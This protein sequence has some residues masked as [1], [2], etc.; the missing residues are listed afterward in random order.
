MH[1]QN[2]TH[3]EAYLEAVESEELPIQRAFAPTDDERLTREMILQMKLGR[4]DASYFQDKFGIDVMSR[5]SAPFA[6]LQRRSMLDL[7]DGGATL[8]RQ[9]LLRVDTLLPE[10]YDERYQNARYT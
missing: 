10:F 4:V 7:H 6:R 3:W 9:G 1:Y 2:D 8:T 5:Y